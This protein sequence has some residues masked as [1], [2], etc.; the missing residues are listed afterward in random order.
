MSSRFVRN[1]ISGGFYLKGDR[2]TIHVPVAPV[3]P[4]HYTEAVMATQ[5][6]RRRTTS[7]PLVPPTDTQDD[8]CH[9]RAKAKSAP[10]FT[11]VGWD[12]TAPDTI[13]DWAIRA[14]R[15]GSPALKVG[16][17][18]VDAVAFEDYQRRHGSKIPD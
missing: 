14:S 4:V 6:Q 16:R 2:F 3:H 18:L 5:R 9:A 1:P 17:A 11:L 15:A 12:R 13:R 7:I 10:T 8:R